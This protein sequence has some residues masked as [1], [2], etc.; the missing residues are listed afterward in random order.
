MLG[1]DAFGMELDAVRGGVAVAHR[2]HR[3]VLAPRVG[4]QRRRAG[5]SPRGCGS[6]SRRT[7]RAGRR[8]VRCRHGAPRRSCRASARPARPRPPHASAERLVAEADAEQRPALAR[9]RRAASATEIPAS[10]GR[11]GAGRN[12]DPVAPRRQRLARRRSRHCARRSTSAPGHAQIVREHEGEA[13][14][15]VEQ[16]Q[17]RRGHLLTAAPALNCR[18]WSAARAPRRS[19]PRCA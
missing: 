19:L 15:I 18:C 1:G 16:Q 5:R 9:R 10:L 3:A 17:A 12:H 7:A 11:A 13:V 4:D 2:H 14:D 8:T 6:A